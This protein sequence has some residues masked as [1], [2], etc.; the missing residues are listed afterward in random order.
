MQGPPVVDEDVGDAQDGDEET[1]APLGLE[2]D[3]DHDAGGETEEGDDGSEE[4]ELAL[5][6]EPDK[7]EDQE[8]PSSELEATIHRRV[9]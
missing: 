2:T 8:D 1:G 9:T 4:G 7:E 5:E 3:G 6:G